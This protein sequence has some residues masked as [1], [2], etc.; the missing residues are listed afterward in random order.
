MTP[1]GLFSADTT[2]EALERAGAQSKKSIVATSQTRSNTAY[3]TL[4]TPDQVSILLPQDGLIYVLFSAMW[5]GGTGEQAR[6]AIFIDGNQLRARVATA[7]E[8]VTV[9]AAQRSEFMEPLASVGAL[10]IATVPSSS[11]AAISDASADV[12]TGMSVGTHFGSAGTPKPLEIN[13][14]TVAQVPASGPTI[15]WAEA[16]THTVSIQYKVASGAGVAVK[17]R[18]LWVWAKAF[19]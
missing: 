1:T 4:T 19:A 11:G 12:T 6:A 3:G 5:G 15:I 17:N 18:K 13:G 16:G 8:P 14:T 2:E 10:G 7:N 9:A